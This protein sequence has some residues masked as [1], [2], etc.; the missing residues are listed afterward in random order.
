MKETYKTLGDYVMPRNERNVDA[1]YGVNELRG[2]NSEGKICESKANV[3]GVEF[4]TY[5]IAYKGDFIYNPARLDIGSISCLE[6]EL[7]I[8]SQMYV[9]F[10][11]KE[12]CND[13]LLTEYLWLWFKRPEFFR[14]VGFINF[15]SV[16][17]MFSF[18]DMCKVSL[19]VPP[20]SEQRRIVNEYQTVERR[21]KNNEALIQKLEETAQAIYHHTFVEGI[22]ENNL[23]EGWRMGCLGDIATILDNK[24]KP[25]SSEERASLKGSYPYYGAMSI[26]D[27]INDYLFDGTYLLFSEDGANV[28]DENGFPALQYIW[29]KFWLNNHAHILQG[30]DTITTEFLYC[31]LRKK[32]VADLV[33]GAAQPKINQENMCSISL[34][35]GDACAMTEFNS[36]IMPIFSYIKNI[37]EETIRLHTLLSLFTSKLA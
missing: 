21:I 32:Y 12:E 25:L 34:L 22:D 29:G 5:K 13:I 27:Y 20:I 17:E 8:V 15:G 31:S 6:E 16:R 7:C 4:N 9:V 28:I 24:R 23:P 11:V 37:S 2:V 30:K 26:V 3:V 1:Q 10:H 14:Y 33:T 18:E 35:V 36:K 19:P